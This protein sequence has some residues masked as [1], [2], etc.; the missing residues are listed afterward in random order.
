MSSIGEFFISVIHYFN[1]IDPRYLLFIR[2]SIIFLFNVAIWLPISF[3]DKVPIVNF[4]GISSLLVMIYFT[5]LLLIDAPAY[6][7]KHA[8]F[9]RVL[10]S[11]RYDSYFDYAY[12]ATTTFFAFNASHD[13]PY[14]LSILDRQDLKRSMK[15]IIYSLIPVSLFYAIYTFGG[16]V[17]TNTGS[18]NYI[19]RLNINQEV[20]SG[21]PVV[22]GTLIIC[23]YLS[24]A[25]I[26]SLRTLFYTIKQVI[27]G[28]VIQPSRFPFFL[29][30]YIAHALCVL[31]SYKLVGVS[32]TYIIL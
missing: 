29:M 23:S 17:R 27:T 5:I 24:L 18:Y 30:I 31:I 11:A 3:K 22:I 9:N 26:L 10:Y 12:F 7:E 8:D 28:M 20:A 14:S 21:I 4:I 19:M 13:I 6:L 32:Y 15:V 16:I 25:V 2:G 1:I